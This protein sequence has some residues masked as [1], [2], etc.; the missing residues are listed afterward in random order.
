MKSLCLL[1]P[2]V[3]PHVTPAF[4]SEHHSFCFTVRF[5][6]ICSVSLLF[7]Y[8]NLV[9]Y[10]FFFLRRPLSKIFQLSCYSSV[11]DSG[12]LHMFLPEHPTR[13]LSIEGVSQH[14]Q[15]RTSLCAC[16]TIFLYCRRCRVR[17]DVYALDL[18]TFFY[19][20]FVNLYYGTE[21]MQLCDKARK[22]H[23]FFFFFNGFGKLERGLRYCSDNQSLPVLQHLLMEQ[24]P[25]RGLSKQLKKNKQQK[26]LT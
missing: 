10:C 3:Q 23:L 8:L 12:Q 5:A 24:D 11:V 17:K 22:L 14:S 15:W 1:K 18:F 7:L 21:D 19:I 25:P 26:L 4:S 20:D 13:A 6:V 9:L 16:I 2:A